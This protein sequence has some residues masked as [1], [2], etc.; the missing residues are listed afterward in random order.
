MTN[1][2]TTKI[3]KKGVPQNTQN[4]DKKKKKTVKRNI[5]FEVSQTHTKTHK[6][7]KKKEKKNYGISFITTSNTHRHKHEKKNNKKIT[8]TELSQTHINMRR[9]YRQSSKTRVDVQYRVALI[10]EPEPLECS[11][12][13]RTES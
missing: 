9:S 3:E 8:K 13:C 11:P 12:S 2:Q 1:K 4:T 5:Y 10:T 7:E 6:H